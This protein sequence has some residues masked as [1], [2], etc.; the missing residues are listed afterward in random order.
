MVSASRGSGPGPPALGERVARLL[1]LPA[2]AGEVERAHD[3]EQG[4]AEPV[5]EPARAGLGAGGSRGRERGEPPVA[6]PA[7]QG[8]LLPGRGRERG[9]QYEQAAVGPCLGIVDGHLRPLARGRRPDDRQPA[10]VGVREQRGEVEA[11]RDRAGVRHH[12]GSNP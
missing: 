9:G 11:G 6:H 2:G 3:V 1:Q 8:I 7:D 12:A 10:A 5:R 4:E